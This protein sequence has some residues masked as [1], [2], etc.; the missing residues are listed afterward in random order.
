[1]PG[2]LAEKE[3]PGAED[4]WL[5]WG[6]TAPASATTRQPNG[7]VSGMAGG[8]GH[9]AANGGSHVPQYMPYAN[10]AYANG[11]GGAQAGGGLNEEALPG[12]QGAVRR[13][14]REPKSRIILVRAL[15]CPA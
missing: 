11:Y 14:S 15:L 12:D 10:G 9:P 8:V 5:S 1:M 7:L 6:R 3:E 13:S 2:G 4:T